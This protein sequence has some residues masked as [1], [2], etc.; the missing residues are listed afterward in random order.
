MSDTRFF[1]GNEKP[2]R[3]ANIYCRQP[4]VP[5]SELVKIFSSGDVKTKTRRLQFQKEPTLPMIDKIFA[6]AGLIKAG[7]FQ[8]K[9]GPSSAE[10]FPPAGERS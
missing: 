8:P 10:N 3:L 5:F 1:T 6:E 4:S 7:F 9:A 2:L